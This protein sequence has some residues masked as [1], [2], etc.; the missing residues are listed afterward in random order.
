M[1]Y[2]LGVADRDGVGEAVIPFTSSVVGTTS[3]LK[4]LIEG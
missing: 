4:A 1:G 2:L 3:E